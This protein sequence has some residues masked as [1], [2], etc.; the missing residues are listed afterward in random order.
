MLYLHGLTK[1]QRRYE[2]GALGKAAKRKGK[3]ARERV[4]SRA[5]RRSSGQALASNTADSAAERPSHAFYSVLA[6]TALGCGASRT[7]CLVPT[8][9]HPKFEV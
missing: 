2:K 5:E 8:P 3:T 6:S 7:S 9:T 1:L 4:R